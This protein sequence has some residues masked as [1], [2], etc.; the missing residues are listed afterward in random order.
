M[1]GSV[2]IIRRG[3][4]LPYKKNVVHRFIHRRLAQWAGLGKHSAQRTAC[5]L[6]RPGPYA[7]SKQR[8]KKRRRA[9]SRP[10]PVVELCTS[11]PCSRLLSSPA[12]FFHGRQNAGFLVVCVFLPHVCGGAERAPCVMVRMRFVRCCRVSIAARSQTPHPASVRALHGRV[13]ALVDVARSGSIPT[14]RELSSRAARPRQWF[15]SRCNR[16]G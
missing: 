9:N 8:G 16:S 6:P 11:C 1:E 15:G 3:L 13:S 4:G 10:N 2:R 12:H 5:P 7:P 14:E